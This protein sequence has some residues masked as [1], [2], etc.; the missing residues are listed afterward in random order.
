M[1]KARGCWFMA[2]AITRKLLRGLL[3]LFLVCVISFFIVVNSPI[4]T[5]QAQ[6]GTTSMSMSPEQKA[7]I[8]EYW[9]L[10]K[11]PAERFLGWLSS[12]VRGDFGISMI[13]RQ[14][15]WDL[16]KVRF[17]NTFALMF[18][19]WCLTGILG[20]LLGVLAAVYQGSFL[21][22][23]IRT[24]C[25]VLASSPKFWLG[26]LALL[27]FSGYLH[28][29]PIGMVNPIGALAEETSLWTKIHHMILPALTLSS[30]SIASITLQARSKLIEVLGSEFV[31]LA[32]ANKKSRK[33]IVLQHGLRNIMLPVVT[34]QFISFSELF[35][36][37]VF[38]EQIFSYPGLAGM[39][40][41]AGLKGDMALL[42]GIVL[43]SAI[44]VFA[45]NML[46]DILYAVIDPRIKQAR[47]L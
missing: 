1:T 3:L 14:P 40:Q 34:L 23:A 35:G 4:D 46:A 7:L 11:P 18:A 19:A 6:L 13:Y 36:G 43:I 20:V 22:K 44:W 16:I 9:G 10:D 33:E 2:R 47:E 28:W 30:V 31:L 41:E 5:L 17:A 26:L 25:M 24:Y 45:G 42:L 12:I 27:L 29:F 15:V 32:K 21:D 37:A 39:V 38:I 8:V